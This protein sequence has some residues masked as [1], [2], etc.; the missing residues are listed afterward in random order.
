MSIMARGYSSNN[1]HKSTARTWPPLYRFEQLISTPVDDNHSPHFNIQAANRWCCITEL[2]PVT[3]RHFIHFIISVCMNFV[4]ERV[5]VV[6]LRVLNA[7]GYS[8]APSP[9]LMPAIDNNKRYTSA[10][11]NVDYPHFGDQPDWLLCLQTRSV[12]ICGPSLGRVAPAQV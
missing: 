5:R 1:T 6:D 4:Y 3:G 8:R 9:M 2:R 10:M 11:F 7:N 12:P